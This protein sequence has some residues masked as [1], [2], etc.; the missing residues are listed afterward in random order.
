MTS[1]SSPSRT[2]DWESVK[3]RLAAAQASLEGIEN[4]SPERIRALMAERARQLARVPEK[5]IDTSELLEV[6]RF[7]VG[8]E[9]VAIETRFVL[10]LTRPKEITPI[11]DTEDFFLGLTNLRGAVTAIIDIGRFLGIASQASQSRT[12]AS[13]SQ[14][15]VLGVDDRPDCAI[16]VDGL[17]HVTTIR[18]QDILPTSGGMGGI[19]ELLIGS[20]SDAVMI[21]DGDALLT[22][23]RLYIDQSE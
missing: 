7:R 3:A 20:T 15:L 17:Q 12:Q 1:G 9:Q 5:T 2:F 8:S 23:D 10:A 22:C 19:A 16:L 21:L 18:K 6:V 4:L 14:T 13:Q 11:P